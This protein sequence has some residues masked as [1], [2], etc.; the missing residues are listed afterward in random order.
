MG[1]DPRSAPIRSGPASGRGPLVSGAGG[2]LPQRP[3]PTWLKVVTVLE[4]ASLALLLLNVAL[5]HAAGIRSGIGPVHG[6]L[7]L[8]TIVAVCALPNPAR[9]RWFSLIPAVGGLLAVR[10]IDVVARRDAARAAA[11]TGAVGTGLA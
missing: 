11:P 10:W 7:Y 4:T 6:V 5:I 2:R 9:A 3:A 8:V 1:T